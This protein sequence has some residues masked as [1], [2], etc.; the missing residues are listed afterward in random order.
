[1]AVN[2]VTEPVTQGILPAPAH[3]RAGDFVFVSSLYPVD[4]T[5]EVVR[6]D[7]SSPY[8]GESEMGAQS[9]CVLERLSEA[10]EY[11]RRELPELVQEQNTLRGEAHLPRFGDSRPAPEQG[12]GR[13]RVMRRAERPAGGDGSP[14]RSRPHRRHL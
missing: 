6:A 14:G 12:R 7:S 11:V 2:A 8:L 10:I 5:G 1:M 9:R 13:R 3:R 4:R